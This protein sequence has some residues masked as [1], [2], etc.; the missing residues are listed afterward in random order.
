MSQNAAMEPMATDSDAA[1]AGF[2]SMMAK[3]L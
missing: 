2:G 3:P 1:Y